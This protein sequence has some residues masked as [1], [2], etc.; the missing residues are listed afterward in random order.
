M[1]IPKSF[2]FF[3]R[4]WRESRGVGAKKPI[5]FYAHTQQLYNVNT[6][7]VYDGGCVKR[8]LM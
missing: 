7:I 2:S 6:E 4:G 8:D 3:G 1:F 5:C